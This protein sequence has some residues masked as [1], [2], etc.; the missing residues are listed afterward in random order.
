MHQPPP[1][2]R[3]ALLLTTILASLLLH[4]TP[5][6][7]YAAPETAAPA[8][9]SA[10]VAKVMQGNCLKVGLKDTGSLGTDYRV[11]P[12]ILFDPSCNGKFSASAD[13]LAHS[14]EPD[15]IIGF[16]PD[17]FDYT[18]NN[19]QSPH[20][21]TTNARLVNKS[22]VLYRGKTWDLR[23]I[24]SSETTDF[25]MENDFHFNKNSKFIEIE[26]T[27]TMKTAISDATVLRATNASGKFATG[28][29]M[30]TNNRRGYST[31]SADNIVL[32]EHLASRYVIALYSGAEANVTTGINADRDPE[33]DYYLGRDDGDGEATIGLVQTY[34]AVPI[35]GKVVFKVAYLFGRTAYEAAVQG[36]EYGLAGGTVGKTPGCTGTTLKCKVRDMGFVHATYTP[37]V[38]TNTP[39]KTPVYTVTNT[40]TI[41]PT[42]I[43]TMLKKGVIGASFVLGLLQNGSLVTWGMNDEYQASLLPCC[44]TGVSDIAVGTNFAVALKNGRVY[45]WGANNRG[46]LNIPAAAKKDVTSIGAGYAHVLAV[47]TNGS[48]VAWGENT[49]R[50]ASVPSTLRNVVQVAGGQRHSLAVTK[51][52]R[53]FGWGA[54]TVGQAQPL[55]ITD[56][57]TMVSAG[58]DH[59]LA[60]LADG[61]VIA[62][63]NNDKHQ[64]EVPKT[65]NDVKYISAGNKYSLALRNDGTFFGWGDNSFSQRA[66]PEGYTGIYTVAA[67]YAN[68]LVGLRNGGVVVLGPKTHDVHITRTPTP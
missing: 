63:G 47:K 30:E 22:G 57:A 41:T 10:R 46:Q 26:T 42:P 59:S 48:V 4:Q 18:D 16:G 15:E 29:R 33:G 31:I 8:D 53:V 36:P 61:S 64:T 7:T 51:S 2:T 45:G 19:N 40:P 60:L 38:M 50:Q 62:W 3:I 44:A 14:Y 55:V 28:D 66:D 37:T 13:F 39:S 20:D 17:W 9:R 56:N 24:Q 11:A 5:Q 65:L 27:F 21:I 6:A 58:L 32:S 34:G 68:S 23:Y 35:G 25:T 43:Q 49:F 1:F 54:N 67:G 12:G 52:G